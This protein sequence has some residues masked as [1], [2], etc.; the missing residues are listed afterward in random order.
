[1]MME[2]NEFDL[3]HAPYNV[4]N[5]ILTILSNTLELIAKHYENGAKKYHDNNWAKGI[6]MR[7]YLD[8]SIRHFNKY[9]KGMDDEPHLIAS[10][11]NIMSL[12]HTKEL[13][14]SLNNLHVWESDTNKEHKDETILSTSN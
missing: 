6:E 3:Y 4:N 13:M 12:L 7:R 1:M 5:N 2:L 10:I 8:S 11:W 9:A 14:P